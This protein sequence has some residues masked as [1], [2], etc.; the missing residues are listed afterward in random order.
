MCETSQKRN[1]EIEELV[2]YKP[3]YISLKRI[4]ALLVSKFKGPN[5]SF[6]NIG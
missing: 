2:R 1:M 4:Y 3:N 5:T 6:D